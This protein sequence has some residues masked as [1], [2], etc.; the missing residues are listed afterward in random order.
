VGRRGVDARRRD[1]AAAAPL[2]LEV[3]DGGGIRR[4]G[5]QLSHVPDTAATSRVASHS[6]RTRRSMP[7]IAASTTSVAANGCWVAARR[8]RSRHAASSTDSRSVVQSSWVTAGLW[9]GARGRQP[10]GC[11]AAKRRPSAE[12][13]APAAGQGPQ[14]SEP[15]QGRPHPL[16]QRAPR[17]V[18]KRAAALARATRP[19][20]RPSSPRAPGGA[21]ASPEPRPAWPVFSS[22]APAPH[23]LHTSLGNEG[24]RPARRPQPGNAAAPRGAARRCG[25]ERPDYGVSPSVGGFRSAPQRP[26]PALARSVL[27]VTLS[28]VSSFL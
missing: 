22:A 6:A 25:R 9:R 1:H 7:P 28:W 8:H 2:G 24:L 3:G 12:G 23:T 4:R 17:C 10:E 26:A 18:Q 11:P 14:V 5:N 21:F 20:R 15:L 19:V 27:R 13:D 16:K